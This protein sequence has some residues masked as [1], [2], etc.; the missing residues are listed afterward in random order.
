[1]GEKMEP[2]VL[3]N[4]LRTMML[5][6]LNEEL[7]L[8][9]ENFQ[10]N[11]EIQKKQFKI[12][13]QGICSQLQ[14]KQVNSEIGAVGYLSFTLL[15][16]ELLIK[17]LKYKIIAYEKEWLLTDGI[18]IGWL[19]VSLFYSY[20]I[21]VWEKMRIECRKYVG[22]LSE[23][24]IEIIMATTFHYFHEYVIQFLRY[25]I[26]EAV[27]TEEFISFKR[28][29]EFCIYTGELFEKL[30]VI[31]KEYTREKKIFIIKEKMNDKQLMEFQDFKE[32]DFTNY[33][34]PVID[35]AYSDF[36]GSQLNQ[37]KF[38]NS[39]LQGVKFMNCEMKKAEFIHCNISEADFSN[40]DLTEANF[41]FAYGYVGIENER[42]WKKAGYLPINFTKSNLTGANFMNAYMHGVD[43][44]K[45]IITRVNFR[46]AILEDC[47]FGF[48]QLED[49]SL[50]DD[51]RL[52]NRV[53][54]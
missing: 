32:I 8:L 50:T 30:D 10:N 31:Y 18:E 13:F 21:N 2:K 38:S 49:I 47:I 48:E 51:Q 27:E 4:F 39:K 14:K 5:P 42:E 36:R 16:T 37:A 35:F 19:D 6:K 34:F 11:M 23:P 15:R 45:T 24:Y 41:V 20:F 52:R 22:K 54:R 25:S 46:G 40:A 17:N 43:F 1:M 28:T 29:D 12:K 33:K 3:N 26:M 44:T 9:E 7:L 53:I